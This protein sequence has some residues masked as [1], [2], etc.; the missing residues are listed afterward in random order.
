MNN[1]QNTKRLIRVERVVRD[2]VAADVVDTDRKCA[3]VKQFRIGPTRQEWAELPDV[4]TSFQVF[5]VDMAT[6]RHVGSD[7]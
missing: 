3:R 5:P 7:R 6:Y 2:G 1:S 4:A